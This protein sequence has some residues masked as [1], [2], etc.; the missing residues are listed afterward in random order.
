M[1]DDALAEAVTKGVP[2]S[3]AMHVLIKM[4]LADFERSSAS[5]DPDKLV[6]AFFD[7]LSISVDS[8]GNL[9]DKK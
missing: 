8:A 5:A 3:N 4:K 2:C 6:S 7:K 1:M 9:R